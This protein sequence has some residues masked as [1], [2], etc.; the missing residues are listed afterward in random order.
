MKPCYI[1][2]A[3]SISAQ[4][5]LN[6]SNFLENTI[7]FEGKLAEAIH[8]NYK[9]FLSPIASRRMATAVKM[10]VAAAK[11]ALELAKLEMPDAI[12]TGTGIGC[13]EDSEKFLNAILD[14]DEEFLT[15]T[16]F[17]QSTHNTVGAQ[18]ALTLKC[19]GYN[20]TYVQGAAS[21]ES[22]VIDAQLMLHENE[23]NTILV[24]GTDELGKFLIN[25]IIF[26]EEAEEHPIQTPFG[27]GAHFF[28]LS[29]Y[30]QTNSFCALKGLKIF[31]K[32]R[33]DTIETKIKAFLKENYLVPEDIDAVILG[34][35]GDAFD[36]LYQTLQDSIFRDTPQLHYKHL[37]GEFFTASAF[38]FWIATN[39]IKQQQIPDV[40]TLNSIAKSSYKNVL[41]YNQLKG[42]QHSFT[43]VTSC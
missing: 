41:L 31:N 4:D 20:V 35:N 12:I 19:K 22:A 9:K 30:K 18:I 3:V 15:P 1:N 2:S 37:C 36:V 26:A 32:A 24:G 38:G 17:I 23:A 39:I 6:D 40:L 7:S 21:F 34:K 8:P 42:Q 11:K 5:T 28:S 13:I 29:S 33:T 10:G 43:L 27:E 16:S 25:D 14:N